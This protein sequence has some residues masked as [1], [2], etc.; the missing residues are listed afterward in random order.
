M[1]A[2]AR[3]AIQRLNE[4]QGALKVESEND[5][6]Y[7]ASGTKIVSTMRQNHIFGPMDRQIL[8]L[9]GIFRG[10]ASDLVC[11]SFSEFQPST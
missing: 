9:S 3:W 1:Y 5:L 4:A 2:W 11:T 8:I 7:A 6:Q 10:Q